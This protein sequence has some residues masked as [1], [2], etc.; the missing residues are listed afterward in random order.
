MVFIDIRPEFETPG[1]RL[2]VSQ[3]VYL[4]E[5]AIYDEYQMLDP[6]NYFVVFDAVGIHSKEAVS[7]LMEHGFKHVASLAGGI[8]DWERDGFAI[9]YN[10]SE[11]LTGS[12]AC[13]L[14]PKSKFNTPYP[15][16]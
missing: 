2:D 15:S 9:C 12:C 16:S 7:F 3:I 4:P 13:T 14:K 8:T 5:K 1:K 10:K 6:A 11:R